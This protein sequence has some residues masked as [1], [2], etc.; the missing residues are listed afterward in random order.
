MGHTFFVGEKFMK[1]KLLN[2]LC[3]ILSI[4]PLFLVIALI[5]Y[6]SQKNKKTKTEIRNQLLKIYFSIFET[7]AVILFLVS[8]ISWQGVFTIIISLIALAIFTPLTIVF[9]KKGKNNISV[10]EKTTDIVYE[11]DFIKNIVI[12]EDYIKRTTLAKNIFY[13]RIIIYN[14]KV[15]GYYKNKKAMT[16]FFNSFIGIDFVEANLNS[17]FAQIVFLTGF[18]SKNRAVGI[19]VFSEQNINAMND[20]NRILFCSGMFSFDKTNA[21]AE[22]I[23]NEILTAFENYQELKDEKEKQTDN[24]EELLKYKKL[25]DSGVISQEEF[26]KKKNELL[27]L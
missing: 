25:L 3:V 19:D 12:S 8:I 18:N 16:W 1:N 6:L 26:N 13:D 20:T 11:D 9:F 23:K 4:I 10:E 17:Q 21:F 27:N 24:T 2:V 15:V 22:M 7:F 5:T 14:N